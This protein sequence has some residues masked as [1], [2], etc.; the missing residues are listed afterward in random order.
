MSIISFFAILCVVLRHYYKLK[1]NNWK[2]YEGNVNNYYSEPEELEDEWFIDGQINLIDNRFRKFI[3]LGLFIDILVNLL[4]PNPFF[5][6]IIKSIEMDRDKNEY[7]IIDYL[8]SDIIFIFIILRIIYLI[9][10]TVNYSIFTDE[11]AQELSKKNGIKS[12]VR[13]IF[14]DILP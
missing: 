9:R 6:F 5:N 12:N 4:V 3:K 1:W 7:I 2:F 14:S 10:A 8:Y 13:F 11:Y